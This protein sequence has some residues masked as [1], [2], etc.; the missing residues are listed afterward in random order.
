MHF[1]V[2]I[3]D[4]EEGHRCRIRCTGQ[5]YWKVLKLNLECYFRSVSVFIYKKNKSLPT[6]IF[7]LTE[8]GLTLM[9]MNRLHIQFV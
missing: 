4:T 9:K 7:F 5:C 6:L 1:D 2:L 3:K 8:N